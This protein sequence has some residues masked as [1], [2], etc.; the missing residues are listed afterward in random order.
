MEMEE[1]VCSYSGVAGG[2]LE[3]MGT[4]FVDCIDVI[5]CPSIARCCCEWLS[6]L[7]RGIVNRTNTQV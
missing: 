1:S 7:S 6:E 2:I 4:P 5:L 3:G